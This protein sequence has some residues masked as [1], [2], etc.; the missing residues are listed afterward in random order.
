MLR[1]R[2]LRTGPVNTGVLSLVSVLDRAEDEVE[3][4]G[5]VVL[6][7]Y[8]S[9]GDGGDVRWRIGASSPLPVKRLHRE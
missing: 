8:P 5:A 7:V 4:A 9:L 2:Y 1:E 6:H 3:A